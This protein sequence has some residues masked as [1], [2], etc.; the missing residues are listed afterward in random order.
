M[1]EGEDGRLRTR[2]EG[3]VVHELAST[4]ESCGFGDVSSHADFGGAVVDH[5]KRAAN[6][7]V[8]G[9]LGEQG[10]RIE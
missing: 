3:R 10:C 4:D 6:E 5:D 1:P 2:A 7:E 9:Y 8:V